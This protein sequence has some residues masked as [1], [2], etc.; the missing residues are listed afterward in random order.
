VHNFKFPPNRD[1]KKVTELRLSKKEK[2]REDQREKLTK[3]WPRAQEKIFKVFFGF[4]FS[5]FLIIFIYT[6]I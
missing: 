4:F 2:N 3:P 6:K 1:N 5:D